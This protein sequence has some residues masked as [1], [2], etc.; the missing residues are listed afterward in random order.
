M[1]Y[2]PPRSLRK[3]CDEFGVESF[4]TNVC[5]SRSL[6]VLLRL[7]GVNRGKQASGKIA[8]L[9]RWRRC[10]TPEGWRGERT[11]EAHDAPADCAACWSVDAHHLEGPQRS[12]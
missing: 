9:I 2:P 3:L 6:S 8:H 12:A 11:V 4:A 5:Q 7:N 1:G 10:Q